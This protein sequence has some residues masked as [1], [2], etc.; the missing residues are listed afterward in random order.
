MTIPRDLASA[1]Q[2]VSDYVRKRIAVW[3]NP[4]GA[5]EMELAPHLRGNELLY[6]ALTRLIESRIRGR[7]KLPVPSDPLACKSMLERDN[8]LR[9]LLSRLEVTYRAPVSH[10]ADEGEPPPR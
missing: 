7:A 4:L 10:P 1:P 8:E 5:D 2:R 3:R 6:N 9:W